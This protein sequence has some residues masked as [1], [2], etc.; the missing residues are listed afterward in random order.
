MGVIIIVKRALKFCLYSTVVKNCFFS[1]LLPANE[2][3]SPFKK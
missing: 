3:L 1:I 2:L